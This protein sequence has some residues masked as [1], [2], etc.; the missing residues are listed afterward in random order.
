MAD[1][2]PLNSVAPAVTSSEGVTAAERYLAKLCRR[3][4]LS[5]WSYPGVFRD[6]KAGEGG[7]GDGKELCDLLIV[8]ENH[9]IIFSDKDCRFD[10]VVDLQVA[11]ARWFKKAILN[12]AKQ[13]WGAERWIRQFPNRLFLDRRCTIPFPISLPDPA[14]MIVHRIV[15]AHDASR[16]CREELGGSGSLMLDSGLVGNAHLN[17]PFTIGHIDPAKGYVHVFDDTTLNIVMNTLDTI[18]DFTAYLTKKEQFLTANMVIHTAG[19]EELLAIYL[20]KMND[21]GEHDFVI[22]GDYNFVLLEEGFWEAFVRSPERQA[23]IEADRISYSWD[24]LIEKFAFYAMSGTQYF[25]S[26]QPLR[27]QEVVFRFLAR[28]PRTRR[29]MLAISLHEVL[30]RSIHS[31]APFDVRVHC[32]T[33][34][35][36]PHYVFLFLKRKPGLTDN[37]YRKFRVNLLSNYCFVAKLKFPAATVIIG[38]AS[39]A[40]LTHERSEDFIYMDASRWSAK[41]QAKAKEIQDRFGLLR[42]VTSGASREYEYP[43]D[44]KGRLRRKSPSRNSPCPCGSRERFKN[45]HGK[46]LFGKKGR[47]R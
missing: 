6:Q 34:P 15:V 40:G 31:S 30:K 3:S 12:S 41:E 18:T 2:G 43:V 37:E 28:E 29:R 45:C 23:Q 44:H 1:P 25:T 10:D 20:R 4:F 11:W 13:V 9:I 26:G 16:A 42:K 5:M 35:G 7:K 14:T 27:E 8:F 17:M 36:F 19:E 39:E 38:I 46:E 33:D 47:R 21:A 24:K 22:E 32:P